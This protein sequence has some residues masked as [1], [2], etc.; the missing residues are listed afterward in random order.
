M[1][2]EKP[3]IEKLMY[4]DEEKGFTKEDVKNAVDKI[5]KRI[6]NG[7]RKIGER[8]GFCKYCAKRFKQIIKEEIGDLKW[9]LLLLLIKT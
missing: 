6:N 8:Y 5:N 3:L 1:K 9:K 2:E 7:K 4:L